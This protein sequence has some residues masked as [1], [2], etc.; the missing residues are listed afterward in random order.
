MANMT[1]LG[2][3]VIVEEWGKFGGGSIV[4]PKVKIGTLALIQ[5]GTI[6]DKDV[7]LY[8][9]AARTPSKYCGLNAIGLQR[10]A[11]TKEQKDLIKEAYHLIYDFDSNIEL[12]IQKIKDT[13]PMTME[14]Q[15]IVD[16]LI[17]C[18][19]IVD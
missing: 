12:A 13:L 17:D 3:E 11:F 8:I 14:I 18:V 15:R 2:E 10:R 5:G 19:R 9:L 4:S 1:R 7:L 16:F 6:I